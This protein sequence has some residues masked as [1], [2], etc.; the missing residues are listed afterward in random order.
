MVSGDLPGDGG[1]AGERPALVLETGLQHRHAVLDSVPHPQ[2]PGPGQGAVL[3]AHPGSRSG[4]FVDGLGQGL[5]A[6]L[7]GLRQAAVGQLLEPIGNPALKVGTVDPGGLGAEEVVILGLQI[8]QRGLGQG[9]NLGKYAVGHGPFS[10]TNTRS[11]PANSPVEFSL[12]L[13]AKR[14]ALA[15][16]IPRLSSCGTSSRWL[17]ASQ[18]FCSCALAREF[19]L[20]RRIT[21][22]ARTLR[23]RRCMHG[24][25]CQRC[26]Q[27]SLL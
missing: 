5:E 22:F 2:Q 3:G 1:E 6:G 20:S 15:R 19:A 12:D 14:L 26:S 8:G 16:E 13:A 7:G 4:A 18:R 17:V 23:C 27:P 11:I 9:C 24:H 25:T 10:G 21:R